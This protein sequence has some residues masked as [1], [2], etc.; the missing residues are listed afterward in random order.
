MAVLPVC[1][2]ADDQLALPAAHWNHGVDGFQAS[3]HGLFDWAAVDH[4][5]CQPLNR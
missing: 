3:L 1:A 4:A 2:V 5:G